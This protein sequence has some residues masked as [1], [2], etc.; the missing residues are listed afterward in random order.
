MNKIS[1][2]INFAEQNKSIAFTTTLKENI[3]MI[4]ISVLNEIPI[5]LFGPPGSSKT[6]CTRLLY[7]SMKG[8]NSK[9]EYFRNLPNLMYK[10]Y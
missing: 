8:K 3:F 6:L 10:T 7:E 5:I 9:I 1:E 4:F 2:I